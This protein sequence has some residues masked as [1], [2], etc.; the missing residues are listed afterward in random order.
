MSAVWPSAGLQ[1]AT[2]RAVYALQLQGC[3]HHHLQTYCP[4]GI[5]PGCD[6]PHK[7]LG[8]N[9]EPGSLG[10]LESCS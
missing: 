8:F 5:E 2:L 1:H 9:I 6:G 3:A 7:P 4:E 10:R